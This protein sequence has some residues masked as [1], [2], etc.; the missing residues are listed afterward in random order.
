MTRFPHF[1]LINHPSRLG[2]LC[3]DADHAAGDI[4]DL[5]ADGQPPCAVTE[6]W[7]E[8][9]TVELATEDFHLDIW[10]AYFI[11]SRLIVRFPNA[12]DG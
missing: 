6:T 12:R 7:D 4:V 9:V 3:H 5:A 2:L 11:R 1:P 10:L 8:S